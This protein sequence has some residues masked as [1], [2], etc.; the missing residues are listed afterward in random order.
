MRSGIFTIVRIAVIFTS[1]GEWFPY[2]RNDRQLVA[3]I[4]EIKQKSISAIVVANVRWSV[5]FLFYLFFSDRS[6]HMETSLN[7]LCSILF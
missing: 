2:D 3:T 1:T 5:L 7:F 6:K 4:A